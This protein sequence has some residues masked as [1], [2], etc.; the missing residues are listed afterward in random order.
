[1]EQKPTSTGPLIGAVVVAIGIIGALVAR[2]SHSA[3]P[4][5]TVSSSPTTSVYK[6]GIYTE[7]GE[8]STPGGIEHISITLTLSNNTVTKAEL[9]QQ[10]VSSNAQFYQ[11]QFASGYKSLVEGKS[12]NEISVTRVS[13]SSLTPTGFMNALAAIKKAAA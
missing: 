12:L 8:Y 13:G 4:S 9:T 3:S 5:A 10:G 11:S 6:D 2:G 1:M 7:S